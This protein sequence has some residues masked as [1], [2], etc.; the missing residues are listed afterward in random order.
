MREKIEEILSRIDLIMREEQTMFKEITRLSEVRMTPEIQELITKRLFELS[1]EDRLDNPNMSTRMKNN[2]WRFNTDL[3]TEIQDKGQNLWGGFSGVTR[4][5]T[6]SMKKEKDN[7][8]AK[9]FGRAGT[10]ERK[11][12]NELVEMVK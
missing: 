12:Y 9:M 4:Y 7:S 10:I 3:Q 11:I 2:I 5:T 6:H 1:V 8:E